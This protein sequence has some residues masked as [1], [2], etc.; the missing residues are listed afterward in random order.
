MRFRR[1]RGN[2]SAGEVLLVVLIAFGLFALVNADAMVRRADRKDFGASRD[3]SLALW[4][5][6]QDVS[7]VF[8]LYRLRQL[9]GWLIGE[10]SFGGA[11]AVPTDSPSTVPE[12]AGGPT[13]TT[14]PL[15]TTT[16]LPPRPA[17]RRPTAAAPLRVLAAGDSMMHDVGD[18]ILRLAVD[19]TL[20]HVTAHHEISSGLTRPDYYDWP[21][22]IAADVEAGDPEVVVLLFGANDAQG[23]V[24]AEGNV[25]PRP[26]DSPGFDAEYRRRVEA[27]MDQFADTGRLVFWIGLPP[28]RDGGFDERTSVLNSIY[29]AAAASRPWVTF[30][31]TTPLFGDAA[32]AFAR[33]ELRKSDGIHFNREGSDLLATHVLGLVEAE[34]PA[35]SRPPPTTVPPPTS[36]PAV[37]PATEG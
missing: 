10:E 1:P 6:V 19:D 2:Q 18:S 20:L 14:T 5:P 36:A 17:L 9:G 11:S 16:T 27:V 7:H 29:E 26:P 8:Q 25:H 37:P 35:G 15:P 22:G 3:R 34:L 28:M 33:P 23:I 24:D 31:D 30:V 21:A 12:V 13:T 32:G 4:N